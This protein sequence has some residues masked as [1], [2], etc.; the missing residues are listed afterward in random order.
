MANQAVGSPNGGMTVYYIQPPNNQKTVAFAKVCPVIPA[1]RF[2][3][4]GNKTA[5]GLPNDR[6]KSYAP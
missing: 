1:L 4:E 6:R 3:D 5:K 2:K